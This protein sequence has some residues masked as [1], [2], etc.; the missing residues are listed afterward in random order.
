MATTPTPAASSPSTSSPTPCRTKECTMPAVGSTKVNPLLAGAPATASDLEAIARLGQ[1]RQKLKEEIAKIIV[2]QEHIVDDLLTCLFARGHCLMIGVPGLAKTLMVRTIA[3]AIDL[4][5]NRIQFTPDLMPSDITGSEIIEEDRATGGRQFR[6]VKGPVF[7]N[8]L[9]ADEINRTPPKTQAALL[10]AMQELQVTVGGKTYDLP[11]PFFVLATQNPIE[12]E[13]TYP[14]P[15][16]QLDRFMFDIRISYP[17]PHE[18][19]EIAKATTAD[20]EIGV[21]KVLTGPQIQQLQQIVRRLPISDHV[22]MYAVNLARS[23][24][25]EDEIA[26]GF[27]KEFV[28]WGAGTRAVQYLVLGAK[29]RAAIAGEYNVT[30]A[31]VRAVAPLVL[32]H[33]IMTNFHG[34]A[35]GMT[36]ERI[37]KLLLE[38]VSEPRPEDYT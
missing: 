19:L 20:L 32:R 22:G 26:P 23:S 12:Q 37:A 21:A 24:R 7:A 33:R 29:A 36:P 6:F 4:E 31:H 8:I 11:K 13:G 9:L 1:A 18:E 28:S 15:E 27:T 25:P 14:L 5:F 10:Q 2:G 38:H 30:C 16:A 3:R 17:K 34:E 35:E